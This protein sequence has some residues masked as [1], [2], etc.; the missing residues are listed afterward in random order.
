MAIFRGVGG[1]GTASDNAFLLE[2][3]EASEAAQA[4]AEQ[5][6]QSALAAVNAEVSSATFNTSDGVLTLTKTGGATVTADLDGRFL[7]SYTE[8][9]DLSTAV[10]W[11]DVPDANI[12]ETSVTQHQSAINAGV[13]ITESQ[14]SNLG[15]YLTA[16]DITGKADTS[17]DTFTGDVLFNDGIKAKFG[18]DSDLLI[19]HNNGEPS[20]IEDAGELGLILKTNGNVFAV[21][22]NT[23]ESMIVASPDGGVT[24]YYDGSPRIVTGSNSV[25]VTTNTNFIVDID[26]L[27]VDSVNDRV[28]INDSTPSEA[29]DVNGNI[30]VNGTVDGRDVA[31]DGSKLDNIEANADVTDTD[32][33]TLAGAAMLASSPTFTG[34]IT[35]PNVDIST[36]G[37][38]TTNI[39]TGTGGS[40]DT[41]TLNLGTGF[42]SFLAGLTTVNIGTQSDQCQNT[43]NIGSGVLNSKEDTINLKGNVTVDGTLSGLSHNYVIPL[44][45]GYTNLSTS[46]TQIGD[47]FY[48]RTYNNKH[49]KR[50]VEVNAAM[51]Y[52]GTTSTNDLN[53][54]VI[55]VVP[56]SSGN[57]VDIG[58]VVSITTTA[59]YNRDIVIAGDVTHWFSD[60]SGVG[61]NSNGATPFTT[62]ASAVYN[63]TT[64]QT[65]FNAGVYGAT[66][67]SVGDSIYVHP[68]DWESAGSEIYGHIKQF[69]VDAEASMS[70]QIY[71]KVYFGN[72]DRIT[73]CRFKFYETASS[74]SI[75]IQRLQAYQTDE[76][77]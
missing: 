43:V 55:L 52:T 49:Y 20:V 67:P 45:Q 6:E 54:R 37:T 5:A 47:D 77:A 69:D 41:K 29:L 11:A 74:D 39:A 62:V 53:L 23:D 51:G 76:S 48:L 70:Y 72:I 75:N 46:P 63:P 71:T 18:T 17:G 28:G 15:T 65:T 7:T 24:L 57:A 13:S 33:V 10:T 3:S 61:A 14:I 60:Y 68:F 66:I 59:I 44:F 64:D 50:F 19:Y 21:S 16:S 73:T 56:T 31:T 35:A 36:T 9:N 40:G 2:I 42:T 32:N 8:T 58:S 12:T 25:S 30:A 34:T 4:A 22:S 38:V 26:T 1:A 27:F